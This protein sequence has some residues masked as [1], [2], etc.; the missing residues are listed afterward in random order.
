MDATSARRRLLFGRRPGVER[1]SRDGDGAE[2]L[3]ERVGVESRASAGPEKWRELEH[4][5]G[6]P[7]RYQADETAQV[8]PFAD[9]VMDHVLEQI[10]R[11]LAL[12]E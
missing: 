1:L 10:V 4:S 5:L 2:V 6:G 12:G 3:G 11:F 7:Q 9:V 8:Q